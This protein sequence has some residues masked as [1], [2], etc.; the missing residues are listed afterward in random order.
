MNEPYMSE[1]LLNARIFLSREDM[2]MRRR[3]YFILPDTKTAETIEDELLLARIDEGHIHFHTTLETRLGNKLPK[4]NILQK[5]DLLHA[6]G[7]GLVS[8]GLTG[9]IVGAVL[10]FQW[11]EV[12]AVAP[13]LGLITV[14]SII[15][16]VFGCWAAGMIGI[17]CP[18]SRL[19]A[20]RRA[21]DDGNILL[22]VD[23][24]KERV[25]EITRLIKSHHPQA[26][27]KGIE[28]TIPAFP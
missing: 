22:M 7:V 6:M 12:G 15:G 10:Y 9:T 25:E 18:N 28:A 27:A 23:V 4:A 8:G 17:S 11:A 1:A 3:L 20:F 13:G 19:K 24:P 21:I 2:H 26:D 5:S 16:A 14:L